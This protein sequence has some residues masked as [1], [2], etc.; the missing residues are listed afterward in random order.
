VGIVASL[1]LTPPRGTTN[2]AAAL[3]VSGVADTGVVDCSVGGVETAGA[4]TEDE[5]LFASEE[6]ATTPL[7]APELNGEIVAGVGAVELV[8]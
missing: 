4:D 5:V 2:P 7:V 1:L 8:T 3:L 6:G